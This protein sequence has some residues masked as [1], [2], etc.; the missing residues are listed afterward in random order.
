[1]LYEVITLAIMP[2][3]N[4][5]ED[6]IEFLEN[7]EDFTVSSWNEYSMFPGHLYSTKSD[8]TNIDETRM[9]DD[10]EVWA[11][12]QN[13]KALMAYSK[14]EYDESVKICV[15]TSYSIHYTKL[16]EKCLPNAV[17]P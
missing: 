11:R 8:I 9:S 13:I 16:Y 6:V 15:I 5:S 1:M 2:D 3:G 4:L 12:E 17:L 14:K 7:I 10:I